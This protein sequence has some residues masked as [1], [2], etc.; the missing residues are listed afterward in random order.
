VDLLFIVGHADTPEAYWRVALPARHFHAP[1]V[2]VEDADAEVATRTAGKIWIHQPTGPHA[3]SLIELARSRGQQVIVDMSEDP[4]LRG[5]TGKP[6]LQVRLDCCERALRS[7]TLIVATSHEL[8]Q[9]LS[10]YGPAVALEPVLELDGWEPEDPEYPPALLWWNDGRQ[11]LGLELLAD[12]WAQIMDQSEAK[13]VQ[14]GAPNSKPFDQRHIGRVRGVMRGG[15]PADIAVGRW[16]VELAKS[17]LSV[18][19]YPDGA[20]QNSLSEMA[21]LRSAALGVPVLT[22]RSSAPAGSLSLDRKE[23]AE[24]VLQMIKDP[25]KRWLLSMEARNW[26]EEH[27]SYDDYRQILEV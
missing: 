18:E 9:R 25:E 15:E 10:V 8:A 27:S 14:I 24:T 20:Y 21:L 13:M 22:T 16:K 23:W 17:F 12:Q 19:C 11:R 2:F 1:M 5:D 4:W 26:A 6:Y 3:A 7:A